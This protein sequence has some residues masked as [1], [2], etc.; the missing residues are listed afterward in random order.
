MKALVMIF[1]ALI[2]TMVM[3]S[4]VLS[5]ALF[6]STPLFD[7]WISY[8]AGDRPSSVVAADLDG[9]GKLDLIVA[10]YGGNNVSVFRNYGNGT[11][12]SK[13]DYAAGNGPLSVFVA[14]L[15][16]DGKP[17]LVVANVGSNTVS[18]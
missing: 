7:T 4:F 16:G 10:N 9:D 17:D 14:D 8:D 5:S 6:A 11:F 13:A 18:V 2:V 3:M 15:D 12:A 1:L